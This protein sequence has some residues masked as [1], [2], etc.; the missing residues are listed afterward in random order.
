MPRVIN[1]AN[2][3]QFTAVNALNTDLGATPGPVVIPSCAQVVLNW[4]LADAKTAHN[5]LYGR[6]SGAFAGTQAQANTI[7]TALT[8]GAP[9][10][11]LFGIL[12]STT[13]LA[14]VS[15]RNVSVQDQPL[16]LS[17]NAAVPG[18]AGSATLPSEMAEVIT[19]RTA[20]VGRANRGRIYMPPL[21]TSSWGAGDIIL[22]ASVTILQNWANTLIGA[23]ATAG[24]TLV[25]GQRARAAYT[26]PITGRVFPARAATNETVTSL[27]VRD[28]HWDS[29]RRRGLR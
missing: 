26:S 12:G 25:I 6:Y 23:L 28:N 22:A 19:E 17:S 20:K 10:V 9:A 2:L 14:G 29:Q 3:Q 15:I 11:A 8:T 27:S 7:H 5:V 13:A 1:L 18:T 24:Y 4:T 16:V 21:A